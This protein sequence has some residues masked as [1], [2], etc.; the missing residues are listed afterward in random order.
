MD[1]AVFL[2]RDGTINRDVGWLYKP[3]DLVFINGAVNALIDLQKNYSLYIITN[4][5]GIGDGVFSDGE[6]EKF[7]AYFTDKLRQNKVDI[8]RILHCPH[9]K[10]ENCG[11]KKP[12]P[13]LINK[14]CRE[15]GIKAAGSYMIGDHP[16]DIEAG[17]NAGLKTIY[18]LTG[19]GRKHRNELKIKPDHT[20]ENLPEAS[21]FI[22]NK[23]TDRSIC[24]K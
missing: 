10:S 11:C 8:K 24:R 7:T 5:G 3:E 15:D 6:Y 14:I 12:S 21:E 20:A 17:L 1:R 18:L 9:G 2:D 22:L 23:D 4:Q 16:H 19:H 13:Y